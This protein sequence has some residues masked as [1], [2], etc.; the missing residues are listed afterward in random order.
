M[1]F[2]YLFLMHEMSIA[3]SLMSIIRDEM[4]KHGATRLTLVRVCFGSLS[5]IVPEALDMAFQVVN[6]GTEFE[7]AR[8]EMREDPIRLE[9]G[10]CGGEFAPEGKRSSR[11]SPCPVCGREEGHRVLAGKSLFIEHI[12]VE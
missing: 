7:G 1:E 9:C 10:G 6:S 5:N 12:E 2:T 8:L 4:E 11:F 3:T